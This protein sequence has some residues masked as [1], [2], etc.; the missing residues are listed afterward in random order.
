MGLTANPERVSRRVFSKTL[1][2][3]FNENPLGLPPRDTTENPLK[4]L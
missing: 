4:T 2:M 1:E 3:G